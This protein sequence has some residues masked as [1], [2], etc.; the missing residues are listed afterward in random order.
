MT[1]QLM[2][3][4]AA[5]P[6][7]KIRAHIHHSATRRVTRIYASTLSD[8]TTE[9]LKNSRPASATRVRIT[10]DTLVSQPDYDATDT[11]QTRLTV[12]ITDDGTAG[13]GV[14]VFCPMTRSAGCRRPVTCSRARR[15]RSGRCTT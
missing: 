7:S 11:G 9:A 2:N 10:I 14:N 1:G 4:I 13:R 6:P 8:V 12:T 15:W 5:S 3:Q